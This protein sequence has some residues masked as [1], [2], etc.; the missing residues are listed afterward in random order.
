MTIAQVE[1]ALSDAGIPREERRR[2]AEEFVASLEWPWYLDIE[3]GTVFYRRTQRYE[4]QV[5]LPLG[6]FRDG[7]INRAKVVRR[8]QEAAK[9]DACPECGGPV[10]PDVTRQEGA[11]KHRIERAFCA[12]CVIDLLRGPDER[13]R[14]E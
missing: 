10:E 13:W 9:R 3:G 8:R 4:A 12:T 11:A 6:A 7:S 1:E 14:V 2:M 5:K